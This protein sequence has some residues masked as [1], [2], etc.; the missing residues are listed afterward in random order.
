M[1]GCAYLGA[2]VSVDALVIGLFQQIGPVRDYLT[3]RKQTEAIQGFDEV[4]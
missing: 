4:L 2:T 3:S 1:K